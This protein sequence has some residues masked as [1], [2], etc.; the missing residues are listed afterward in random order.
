MKKMV[1]AIPFIIM[2]I[3]AAP[4]VFAHDGAHKDESY[5]M[6]EEGSGG[7]AME[8]D[9]KSPSSVAHEYKKG[10]GGMKREQSMEHSK[11]YYEKK[12]GRYD[13][14]KHEVQEEGSAMEDEAMK[15]I[16]MQ[17]QNIEEGSH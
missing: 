9:L 13:H 14:K 11:E 15:M 12:Y 1:I 10:S 7:S 5:G 8:M 2:F 16:E 17:H 6:Y 3:F 4:T